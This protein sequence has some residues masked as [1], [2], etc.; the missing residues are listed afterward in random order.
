LRF[1]KRIQSKALS[2]AS[3]TGLFVF[4]ITPSVPL[5]PPGKRVDFAAGRS[6]ASAAFFILEVL[7]AKGDVHIF[8][9]YVQKANSGGGFNLAS[10]T[11]K[12]G[13][14]DNG[15]VPAANTADPRWGAGGTTDFSAHEVAHATGYA[16]PVSLT[17]VAFTRTGAVETLAAANVTIAQDAAGFANGYYAIIYDATAA[18]NYAIG[19]VDLGGPVGNVNGPININWNGSGIATWTSS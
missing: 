4:R 7:M 2:G 8:A 5:S 16:A 3:P 18:G 11:I 10:D 9:A 15:V 13:I 12:I 6:S 1:E 14:V 19:F 17:G